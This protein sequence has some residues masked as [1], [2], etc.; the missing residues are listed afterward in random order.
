[1]WLGFMGSQSEAVRAGTQYSLDFTVAVL[2]SHSPLKA[3]VMAAEKKIFRRF[4]L[5]QLLLL[6]LG[7]LCQTSRAN[8]VSADDVP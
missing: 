5:F 8:S 1:M 3:S 4:L 2:L 7:A 6:I